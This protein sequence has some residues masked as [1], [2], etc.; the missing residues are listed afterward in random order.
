M[1]RKAWEIAI[2]LLA[3]GFAPPAHGLYFRL[4]GDRLWLQARQTPL[5]E[6]LGQ[7]TRAGVEVLCDPSIEAT[8]TGSIRGKEL[9]EALDSLLESYDYLLTWKMLRGPLGHVPK[10]KEIRIFLPGEEAASQPI[11]RRTGKFDTT[12]G[13]TGAGPEFVKDELL[14]GVRPGTSYEQFQRLLDEIGGMIV[15]A[16]ATTGVYLI[17]FPPGTNVEALLQRLQDHAL[18]AQAELNYVARL[19]AGLS[20]AQLP[21]LPDVRPPADGAIPVAVLDSGLDPR[22]GL[23]GLVTAGWDAVEP[24]RT[25]ADPQ[26]HG[27]QMAILSSGLLP[28]DGLE[29]AGSALPLASVR[30]FDEDGQTANFAILQ[31]LAY[32]A[33]AGAK[34]VNMSWG[35][36]TDSEFLHAAIQ[37]ASRKGLILVAAAGNEPTGRAV[38]PAAYPEVIAVAGVAGGQAWS[39]SN[40]GDFVDLAASASATL[41]AGKYIGTSISS[42]AVANALARYRALNPGASASAARAAL[43][44]ALSPALATGYG[45]GVLDAAAVQRLLAP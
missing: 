11:P 42:A 43:T 9:A 17:R 5:I 19:P 38:Y 18:V 3:C 14:V 35:S 30:A 4:D 32:A 40:H 10:L 23:D 27:T 7:F 15:E 33:Q 8:V 21:V 26:G 41:P 6:I 34:V 25:L 28:A 12:R 2:L 13:V 31:A 24:G 44:Q 37:A 20:A 1:R 36:E 16:D 45:Q 22:A 29:S 39:G